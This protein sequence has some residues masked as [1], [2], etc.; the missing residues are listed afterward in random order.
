MVG[1]GSPHRMIGQ[2]LDGTLSVPG[3]AVPV[4]VRLQALVEDLG[5]IEG[6]LGHALE[7]LRGV[8]HGALPGAAPQEDQPAPA[9]A[10]LLE[11]ASNL[12]EVIKS[13]SEELATG[14]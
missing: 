11:R 9:V 14:I 5:Q 10:L 1:H 2:A 7:H 4:S 6:R 8:R 3:E 12:V 13:M